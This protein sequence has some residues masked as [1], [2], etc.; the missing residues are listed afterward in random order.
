MMQP[1]RSC[2]L[3][4]RYE[5]GDLA[6]IPATEAETL[7]VVGGLYGNGAALAAIQTRA[8]QERG[9]VRLVF[10]GDFN[11][12]NIDPESFRV[13]NEAV[14]QHAALRGNVE[15]EL[16]SDDGTAGCGCG[17][18][19][20]VGNTEVERSNLIIER[21]RTTAIGLPALRTRLGALPM[22][23]VAQIG[24]LR[25]AVVHGDAESL[26]GWG[27]SQEALRDEVQRTRASAWF[28]AADVRVFASSHTCSP[29]M[30]DF[31]TAQG[32]VV[33]ANNGAA[34]MPNFRNTH[35]G[36]FTRISR[37]AAEDAVYGTT[38]D[39]IRIDAIP[40]SYDVAGFERAFLANWPA[41]SPAYESYY[42]RITAGP[43]YDIANAV[44]LQGA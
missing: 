11:W 9:D 40:L 30:Q 28:T 37:R 35:H 4:Y 31:M 26:A 36:L 8:M 22:Y 6:R 17:Y 25:I 18:P 5:P 43:S 13:V 21:L 38:L 15:T 3:S 41:G 42:R 2:P 33:L 16:A 27:F 20:W 24:Q 10:N 34:G 12:F 32:R 39:G 19:D 44:R 7:Y 23:T 1:G 14:L 29:V